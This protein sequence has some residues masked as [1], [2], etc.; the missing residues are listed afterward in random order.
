M[1]TAFYEIGTESECFVCVRE[2]SELEANTKKSA[3]DFA[4]ALTTFLATDTGAERKK[5]VIDI[6]LSS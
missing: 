3:D 6:F 1:D 2:K 5:A 4:E